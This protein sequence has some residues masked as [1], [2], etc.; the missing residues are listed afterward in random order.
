M[1]KEIFNQKGDNN[2]NKQN[3]N[4][5]VNKKS[6]KNNKKEDI[7]EFKGKNLLE[8]LESKLTKIF[9]EQS[10]DINID[11]M[12]DLK[13]ISSALLI[14]QEEPYEKI[15][16]FIKN[17]FNNFQNELDKIIRII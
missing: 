8:S 11:D 1:N 10:P 6:K 12:N 4:K 14:A 2:I 9:F 13:K 15:N 5:V 3:E 17:N 7:I 16:E